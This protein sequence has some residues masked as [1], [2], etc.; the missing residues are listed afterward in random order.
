[1]E[2]FKRSEKQEIPTREALERRCAVAR[3]DILI[4]VGF[5]AVNLLLMLTKTNLYFLFSAYI[6]H[7]LVD[8][9]MLMC[10][11]HPEELY[12]VLYDAP[13]HSLEF[14]DKG[15]FFLMLLNLGSC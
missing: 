1:M 6:P 13:Y 8:L 4:L 3:R 7:M 12:E 15:F 9:G 10:G 14:T 5:T 2:L 11:M